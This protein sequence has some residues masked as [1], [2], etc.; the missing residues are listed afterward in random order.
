MKII[1]GQ[2]FTFLLFVWF[3]CICLAPQIS[4]S[5]LDFKLKVK[6][7]L[8]TSFVVVVALLVWIKYKSYMWMDQFLN[9]I[10]PVIIPILFEYNLE[11]FF[12]LVCWYLKPIFFVYVVSFPKYKVEWKSHAHKISHLHLTH[13]TTNQWTCTNQRHFLTRLGKFGI[14]TDNPSVTSLL[15]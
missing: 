10:P 1:S 5:L 8:T 9:P 12:L 3:I 13:L 14:W 2:K 4:G 7:E 15:S 6:W 11:C